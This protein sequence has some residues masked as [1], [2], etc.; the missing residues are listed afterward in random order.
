MKSQQNRIELVTRLE[1]DQRLVSCADDG[2]VYEWDVSTGR[3]VNETVVKTCAYNDV[4]ISPGTNQVTLSF[5][6]HYCVEPEPKIKP[7]RFFP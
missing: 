2:S 5:S 1:D 4:A 3:R 7:L 6:Y